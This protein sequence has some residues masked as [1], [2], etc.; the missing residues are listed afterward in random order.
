MKLADFSVVSKLGRIVRTGEVAA[1]L[2]TSQSHASRAMRRLAAQGLARRVS[3]GLWIVGQA[4][5]DPRLLA[6]EITRPHPSYVSFASALSAHGMIDQVPREISLASLD[7]SK[8]QR[9]AV[10][11]FVVRHVP[12][13]LF[14][15]WTDRDGIKLATP[16]K[17]LFDLAYVTSVHKGRAVRLP[18]L[19]LPSRFSTRE[20]KRWTERIP[21]QR[22]RT[23]TARALD[24]MLARARD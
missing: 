20:L 10:G 14:G 5:V 17:A 8:R 3:H 1:V 13:E 4:P 15:G 11:T 12:P 18:E 6:D 2:R 7:D 9:T 23:L 21:S 24:E 22:V 19:E 16:E